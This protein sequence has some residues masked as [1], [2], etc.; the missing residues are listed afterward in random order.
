MKK[1]KLEKR[2]KGIIDALSAMLWFGVF[3]VGG[4]TILKILYLTN[5]LKY[6]ITEYT[7]LSYVISFVYLGVMFLCVK[8]AKKG[9]MYAGV[10]GIIIGILNI[11]YSGIIWEIIGALLLIDSI[12]YLINYNKK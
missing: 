8:L 6:D 7:L 1:S 11:L 9:S 2:K 3:Y 5:V 4:E 10:L 12:M